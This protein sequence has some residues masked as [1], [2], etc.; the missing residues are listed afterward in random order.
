MKNYIFAVFDNGGKTQDRYTILTEPWYFGKSCECLGLSDNCDTPQGFSQWSDC[1][2]GEH[3]G[4]QINFSNLPENVQE[5]ALNR[6]I[7]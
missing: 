5:H 4:K 7:N 3:L 6:I 2:Y 1:F